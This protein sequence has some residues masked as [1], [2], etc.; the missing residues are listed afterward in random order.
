MEVFWFIPS[1]GDGGYLGGAVGARRVDQDYPRQVAVATDSLDVYLSS[2]E[3]PA[4]VAERIADIGGGAA[5]RRRRLRFGNRLHLTACESNEAAWRVAEELV[6]KLDDS[7]SARRPLLPTPTPRGRG[8]M[9][10]IHGGR[11]EHLP[12][13]GGRGLLEGK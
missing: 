4:A 2:G 5:L 11:S 7:T 9:A 8:R 1:H 3:P 13:E 12:A 10:A 6:S